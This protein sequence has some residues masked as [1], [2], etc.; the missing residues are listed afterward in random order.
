MYTYESRVGFS[1]S[2]CNGYLTLNGLLNYFQD[3]ATFQSEDLGVGWDYIHENDMVWMLSS[4]Q[5]E[6]KRYPKSCERIV[7]GTYPYAFK[8]CFG[9]RNFIMKTLD[10]EVLAM[11]NSLWVLLSTKDNGIGRITDKMKAA[12]ETEEKLPMNYKDRRIPYK[13]EGEYRDAYEI[14]KYHLDTNNHVN[15]GKYIELAMQEVP[16]D[17]MVHNFRAEYKKQAFLG[18]KVIPYVVNQENLSIVALK[19]EDGEDF[20]VVEFE[21]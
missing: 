15:N 8:G 14:T 9:Y 11:A 13:E 12:Y 17:R 10:G 18:D 19:G 3:A 4:W 7:I 2:D 5:L 21:W 16:G 20:A 6:I 1:E